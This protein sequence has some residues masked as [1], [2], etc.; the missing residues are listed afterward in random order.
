MKQNNLDRKY[1]KLVKKI[2]RKGSPKS[3]RTGTGTISLFDAKI[4]HDMSEGFPILTSKKMS[5]GSIAAELIWFLS[6]S[7]DIRE[8]WKQGCYIWDGDWY[9][10]YSQSCSSPYTLAEMKLKA[11]EDPFTYGG[12]SSSVFQL[13]PIYGKQWRDF[14]GVDQIKQLIKDIKENPASRRLMVTA[15][16]PSELNQMTLPP[17]HY[18]FQCYVRKLSL[19]ERVK[20]YDERNGPCPLEESMDQL[21][22]TGI[23]DKELSLKWN[24]RSVDTLL[25]LPYNIASYGLLL[26]LLCRAT[27]CVP[28]KLIG[29]LGDTHIYL[30]QIGD[31]LQEQFQ[32]ETYELP[33]LEINTDNT[34]IF[35]YKKEDFKLVGYKNA[36][37]ISYPL[38]N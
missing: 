26:T 15:W 37:K 23:P 13:G 27:D 29:S 6:G 5:L 25:G 22:W 9:K 35:S 32:N 38:S 31:E 2:L 4:K 10:H 30:D 19:D 8:L 11:Q 7:T 16:S 34:D 36:G 18:G 12:V 28:G 20:I 3:D 14:N 17:C 24:Q 1:L 33:Q 21:D